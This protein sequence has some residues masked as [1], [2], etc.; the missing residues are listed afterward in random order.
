MNLW[1][2]NGGSWPLISGIATSLVLNDQS[3]ILLAMMLEV[4]SL[5]VY[6]RLL[7]IF[8]SSGLSQLYD[9]QIYNFVQT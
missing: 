6:Y 9:N 2:F 3:S 4:H 5:R 8:V 7:A 1:F